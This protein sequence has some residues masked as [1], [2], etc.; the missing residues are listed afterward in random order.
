MRSRKTVQKTRKQ[1][2]NR[3]RE[4]TTND[5]TGD[6]FTL[7][8]IGQSLEEVRGTHSVKCPWEELGGCYKPFQGDTNAVGG[9]CKEPEECSVYINLKKVQ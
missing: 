1:L 9:V 4:M 5:I 2:T 3:R 8:V 6:K 7:E